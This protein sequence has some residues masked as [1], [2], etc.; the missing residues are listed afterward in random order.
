MFLPAY[1]LGIS[2]SHRCQF[3][4]VSNKY[5]KE[6]ETRNS[7]DFQ[8][9]ALWF[10]TKSVWVPF[11][12]QGSGAGARR[13]CSGAPPIIFVSVMV[14]NGSVVSWCRDRDDFA[15]ILLLPSQAVF[16]RPQEQHFQWV[17]KWAGRKA[18]VSIALPGYRLAFLPFFFLLASLPP[19]SLILL[20]PPPLFLR[21]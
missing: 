13:D 2:H 6:A 5:M 1:Y 17:W 7:G 14:M 9:K 19:V 16:V 15:L 4:L 12:V 18:M 21:E 3:R 10:Q 20:S 8:T 11:W